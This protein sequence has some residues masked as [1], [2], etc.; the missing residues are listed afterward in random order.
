MCIF[1]RK[2]L[3]FSKISISCQCKDKDLEICAIELETKSSK[4]IILSLYRAPAGDLNQ[5]LENQDDALKNLHKSTAEF[6]ICGNIHP[7]YLIERKK[8][9]K[10]ASVLT[11]Y[12]LLHTINFATRIQNISST[13]INIFVHNSS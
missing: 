6:L 1:I 5:C 11:T 9:K 7:D 8:K 13:A 3:C 10:L 2:D 12:N 4:L